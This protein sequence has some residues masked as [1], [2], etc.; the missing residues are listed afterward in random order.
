MVDIPVDTVDHFHLAALVD[1]CVSP[2]KRLVSTGWLNHRLLHLYVDDCLDLSGLY[3][4]FIS[5]TNWITTMVDD[6]YDISYII[7]IYIFTIYLHI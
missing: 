3:L 4:D 7:Y 6:R 1:V 2:L 5:P